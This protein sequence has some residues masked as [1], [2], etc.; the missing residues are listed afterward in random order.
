MKTDDLI[1]LL[2]ADTSTARGVWP[3]VVLAAVLPVLLAGGLFLAVLGIRPDLTRAALSPLVIWK[4][5][6]PALLA[7]AGIALAQALSHPENRP[8][9]GWWVMLLVAGLG[10]ALVSLRAMTLPEAQWISAIQGQTLLACLASITV[11]GL[12]GLICG[13]IVMRRGATTRPGLSGLAIGL[14]AGGAAAFVYA[15][16]CYQDDTVFYVVWY[17]LAILGLGLIGAIAGQRV[18]RM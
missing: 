2:A 1:D 14:G 3:A 13:L 12:A 8:H 11:I 15:L 6:L 16:H 4:W 17:G 5:L 9:K 18:L 10:V 7:S